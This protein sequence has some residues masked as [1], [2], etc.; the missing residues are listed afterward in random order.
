MK[1]IYIYLCIFVT[2]LLVIFYNY[3][4]VT[5]SFQEEESYTAVIV[6]PRRHKALS[7]VLNSFLTNLSEKWK[8]IIF[9]GN[10]NKEYISDIIQ[11]DLPQYKNRISLQHLPVNNLNT[12]EYSKL[13]VSESFYDKIPTETFLIFQTDTMINEKEKDKINDFLKYDYVG[14][15]WKETRGVGNGGLSLRKKSKMLE[16]I[17]SCKYEGEA[18][19]LFFASDACLPLNKPDF[20]KAKEF[21]VEEVYYDKPFGVHKAYDTLS[22]SESHRLEGKITGLRDLKHY[23]KD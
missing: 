18:E 15:P 19:D 4:P 12:D 8:V 17:R 22:K 14:A 21:S 10:L 23:N 9:H 13:L 5:E 7:F 3:T 20:E 1:Q 2:I 11:K 6:E 16:K